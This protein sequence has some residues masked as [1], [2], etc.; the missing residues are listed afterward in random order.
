MIHCHL[1]RSGGLLL[2]LLTFLHAQLLDGQ[3]PAGSPTYT[4]DQSGSTDCNGWLYD[5]GGPSANYGDEEDHVFTICPDNNTD[6]ILFTLQYYHLELPDQLRFYDGPDQTAPLIRQLSNGAAI[7]GGGVC[8]QLKASSGCLTVAFQSDRSVGF[9][10]WEGYWQCN[11]SCDD[12]APLQVNTLV[13]AENIAET[14]AR[15]QTDIRVDSVNCVG[16][17]IALFEADQTDLGLSRGVVLTNGSAFN[18]VGPNRLDDASF[19][20]NRPGDAD[21]DYLSAFYGNPIASV[22]ACVL[23]LEVYAATDVLQFE[24]IFGSEEYP[25]WV[26]QGFNDIFAFLISGPGID[27]DPNIDNQKNIAILPGSLTPVQIDSVNNQQNWPYFRNNLGGQ[28]LEYDGLT[29]D[30][31]GR[32]KSLTARA[33]VTPCQ[34]YRLKLA[35]ADRGDGEL[36]SGVFLSELGSVE[37]GLSVEYNNELERL[38]EDCSGQQDSLYIRLEQGFPQKLSFA[39]DVKGSAVLGEDYLLSQSDSIHLEAGQ[40]EV[41]LSIVPLTDNLQEGT[42]QIVIC[43]VNDFA[44]GRYVYDSLVIDLFDRPEIGIDLPAD[45]LVICPNEC[46]SLS[47]SGADTYEWSPDSLFL[48]T[49]SSLVAPCPTADQWIYLEGSLGD[50]TDRDSVYVSLFQSQVNLFASDSVLCE[51]EEVVLTAVPGPGSSGGWLIGD[52]S[53]L[54]IAVTPDESQEYFFELRTPCDTQLFRQ[55]IELVPPPVFVLQSI[56]EQDIYEQDEVCLFPIFSDDT[57]STDL[58]YEWYVEE[59]VVGSDKQLKYKMGN[60]PTEFVLDISNEEGCLGT[61]SLLIDPAPADIQFPN[62]FTPNG[63]RENDYFQPVTW[64]QVEIVQ[65]QIFDRYGQKVYDQDDPNRGWSG[66]YKGKLMPSDVYIVL[67][68]YRVG[69]GPLKFYKGD[70]TLIR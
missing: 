59:D 31:M 33:M 55:G 36:D 39:L 8:L 49:D 50:C 65:M 11:S 7:D 29:S 12:F 62:A 30:S 17:Q 20:I 56:P 53:Q 64:G 28:S 42:E 51:G 68:R 23:E 63:D 24:Y 9:E 67:V 48:Q 37:P 38:M 2:L 44:C 19:E 18:M 26:N 54:T 16:G 61:A 52:S 10:G 40:V 70:L 25:E 22:D 5:T 58:V 46:L 60:T 69:N 35:I 66:F 47:A 34:T 21:L 45:S 15:P 3:P 6:C 43:L 32:K 14:L 41:G 13:N 4:I 27:G 1:R 57:D